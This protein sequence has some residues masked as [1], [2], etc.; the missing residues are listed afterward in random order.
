MK[1]TILTHLDK[2]DDPLYDMVANQVAEAL[3]AGKH[4]PSVLATQSDL[5]KLINVLDRRKPD[6]IFNLMETCCNSR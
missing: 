2:P 5:R 6:L 1:I 4:T 3:R